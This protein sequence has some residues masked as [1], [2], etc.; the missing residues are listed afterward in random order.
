MGKGGV[1]GDSMSLAFSSLVAQRKRAVKRRQLPTRFA[2]I[3][4]TDGYRL[5]S[6]R[7]HDRN[8]SGES[9]HSAALQKLLVIANRR[10]NSTSTKTT[11]TA[12]SLSSNT[13]KTLTMS[14]SLMVISFSLKGKH[15]IDTCGWY[16]TGMAQRKRAGLI[17]P[18]S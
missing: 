8:V 9:Y 7:T 1:R 17:T 3:R 16:S 15:R 10:L 14:E 13:I 5:M 2:K 12:G 11:L 18:R 4:K 6:R